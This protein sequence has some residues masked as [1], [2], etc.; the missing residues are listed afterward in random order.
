MWHIHKWIYILFFRAH[1]QHILIHII[2]TT[3]I[4]LISRFAHT[5]QM[6]LPTLLFCAFTIFPSFCHSVPITVSCGVAAYSFKPLESPFLSSS[7]LCTIKIHFGECRSR[8]WW[9]IQIF[10][11]LNKMTTINRNRKLSHFV[12]FW[13]NSNEISDS[14]NVLDVRIH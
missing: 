9:I 2:H 3:R 12:Y 13:W 4:L 14:I 1:V 7:L 6:M 5:I 8:M 11:N 10:S